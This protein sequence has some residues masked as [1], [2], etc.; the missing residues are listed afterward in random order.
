M[1]AHVIKLRTTI[2]IR[3]ANFSISSG[4]TENFGAVLW[5]KRRIFLRFK[6]IFFASTGVLLLSAQEIENTEELF[7]QSRFSSSVFQFEVLSCE[8]LSSCD[9]HSC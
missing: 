7:T 9:D 3:T 4:T 8:N 5:F 2:R 1:L 6:K